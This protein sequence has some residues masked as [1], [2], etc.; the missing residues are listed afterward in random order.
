MSS[1]DPALRLYLS[2]IGQFPL[3][4]PEQ[5]IELSRQVAAMLE[6]K[7][8]EAEG[9]EL[10]AP[11]HRIVKRGAR[12]KSKFMEA[13]LRLV[14]EIAK[15][16]KTGRRTLEMLDL[17]QEGNIGLSRAVE[18]FEP[19]KG[20]KFST[21]AYWWIRQSIQHSIQWQDFLIRMPLPIHN[22]IMKIS[23]AREELTKTLAR[24]PKPQEIAQHLGIETEV[25]TEAIRRSRFVASLDEQIPGGDGTG[26]RA[27]M[28]A[29]PDEPSPDER[30]AAID[31]EHSL[32]R[33]AEIVEQQLDHRARE[34]LL[35]RR[36]GDRPEPWTEIQART[37]LPAEALR[38]IET[39]A[40]ERCRRLLRNRPNASANH[41]LDCGGA[42]AQLSLFNL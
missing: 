12:A 22:Q 13:N 38:R 29:D 20:Y 42:L 4:R 8:R 30:L 23:R 40:M 16:Y 25:L 26:T 10:T 1:Y 32:E 11:E 17:I 3:L 37:G 19:E 5:E 28:L 35:A 6:L 9:Y 7:A 36:G 27:D 21:Y 15:K 24:D 14:V 2:Q 34:V 18:K 39:A 41:L 31:D 33:L